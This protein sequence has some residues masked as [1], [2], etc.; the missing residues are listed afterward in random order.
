MYNPKSK[1]ATEFISHEEI[2]DSLEF[3]KNNKNNK[4][5]IESILEKAKNLK[6]ISHREA[7]LLL[8][9]E[10]E[11]LNKKIYDLAI[12]IKEEFYGNRIDMFAPLYLSN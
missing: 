5:L 10:D 4:Q 2:L 8:D 12:K 1:V 7:L 11:E 9:C 3:A 6:G